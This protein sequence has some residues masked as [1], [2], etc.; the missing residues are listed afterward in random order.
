MGRFSSPDPSGLYYA[1]PTNPQTLNLYSYV[2][3]NPLRFVDRT[4]LTICDWGSSDQ[5]GE[6]YDDDADCA[7]DGGTVVTAQQTENVNAD[8]SDSGQIDLATANSSALIQS[9]QDPV[10]FGNCVKG[11]ADAFSLQSGLQKISGGHLGTGWMSGALLGSSVSSAITLG[12][13]GIARFSPSN[14]APT[15]GETASSTAAEAVGDG[16]GPA[17][18]AAAKRAPAMAITAAATI[19]AGNASATAAVS[20]SVPLGAMARFGAKALGALG[21]LKLPYDLSVASF[22][23]VVCSIGR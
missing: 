22:S 13:Y 17:L 9:W 7:K 6:D 12:Q 23:A 16:A 14:G 8:G 5:D 4:G 1:D 10:S 20:A 2:V 3:N 11:G 15:G 19:R 21:E 18:D